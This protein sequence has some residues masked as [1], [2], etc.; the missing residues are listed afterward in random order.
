MKKNRIIV[1]AI[2]GG[3]LGFGFHLIWHSLLE[4][5]LFSVG[6]HI[7]NGVI[8]TLIGIIIGVIV[9]LIISRK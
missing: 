2:S 6:S 5:N 1:F 4:I 8:H 9:H 3:I 7:I